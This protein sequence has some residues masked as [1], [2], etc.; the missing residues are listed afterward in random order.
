MSAIVLEGHTLISITKNTK[1]HYKCVCEDTQARRFRVMF[2]ATP[3]FQESVAVLRR[4]VRQAHNAFLLVSAKFKVSTQL[5]AE[6]KVEKACKTR[7]QL[8]FEEKNG[9]AQ[10]GEG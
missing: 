6:A 1:S 10:K 2:A 7:A 4:Y 8:I 3:A 9:K 5:K